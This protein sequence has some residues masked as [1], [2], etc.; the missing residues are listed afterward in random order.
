MHKLHY[1]R[2]W[3]GSH[4][5]TRLQPQR[6]RVQTLEVQTD[7]PCGL[8]SWRPAENAPEANVAVD[9]TFNALESALALLMTCTSRWLVT[10][11]NANRNNDRRQRNV[12]V[13]LEKARTTLE[14]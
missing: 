7:G 12:H 14:T 2:R 11:A 9:K 10:F 8:C 1:L 3:P 5:R 13:V 4:L 6:F